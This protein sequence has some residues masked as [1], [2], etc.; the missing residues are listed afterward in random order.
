MSEAERIAK[1][2]KGRRSANGWIAHCPCR[3]H[4][5][6]DR[7]PSLS[8]ADGADGKLLLRCHKGGEFADVMDALRSRRIVE[9]AVSQARGHP[10]ANIV[11]RAARPAPATYS[12]E[13]TFDVP[14]AEI[15]PL[16]RGRAYNPADYERSHIYQDETG[17]PTRMV[18]VERLPDG[19]KKVRQWGRLADGSWDLDA[20]KGPRIPYRLP[21]LL[22]LPEAP[23]FIPEGEKDVETLEALGCLATTRGWELAYRSQQVFCWA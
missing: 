13:E 12:L 20:P 5:R 7:N 6:G 23:V 9:A 2:L 10:I 16:R 19:D 22:S 21:D 3:N 14:D 17:T 15:A 18:T 4:G 11:A 8:I 1:T